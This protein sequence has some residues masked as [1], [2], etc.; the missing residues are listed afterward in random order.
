[1]IHTRTLSLTNTHKQTHIHRASIDA[2]VQAA[3][4]FVPHG[5]VAMLMPALVGA[6]AR[7]GLSA[8]QVSLV[9]SHGSLSTG[10]G[11]S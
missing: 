10:A 3:L 6:L 7:S 5:L 4:I 2:G 1:M 8:W 11:C 9:T